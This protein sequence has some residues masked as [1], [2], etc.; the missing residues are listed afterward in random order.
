MCQYSSTISDERM[1]QLGDFIPRERRF[2]QEDLPALDHDF[3]ALGVVRILQGREADEAQE[4]LPAGGHGDR[5]VHPGQGV[6]G[7]Q[8][9]APQALDGLPSVLL[10]EAQQ[11]A[12]GG[13]GRGDIGI[14]P[15]LR[16]EGL[17][18]VVRAHGRSAPFPSRLGVAPSG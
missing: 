10:E 7:S 6:D 15:Q 9:A 12:D 4:E 11:R 17:D 13:H 1:A 8:E 2:R 18:Q 5:G 14:V 3:L 16:P